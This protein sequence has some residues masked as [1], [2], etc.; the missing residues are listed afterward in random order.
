MKKKKVPKWTKIFLK[1]IFKNFCI[2]KKIGIGNASVP[3]V[4]FAQS[5]EDDVK[6]LNSN[7]IYCK[8]PKLNDEE[9]IFVY[10]LSDKNLTILGLNMK[11]IAINTEKNGIKPIFLL[12]HIPK[13]K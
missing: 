7:F 1:E 3:L 12:L 13:S 2:D 11:N 6:A 4:F 10:A 8:Y 9:Q 5:N